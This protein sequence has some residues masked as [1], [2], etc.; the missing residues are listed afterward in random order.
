MENST[1]L[2]THTQTPKN[3]IPGPRGMELYSLG[4]LIKNRPLET[5]RFLHQTWGD[6]VL[7]PWWNRETIFVNNPDAFRYILKTNHTNYTKSYEYK[8]LRPLLGRGLVTSE[9]KEW[10]KNRQIMSQEFHMKRVEKFLPSMEK[11]TEEMLTKWREREDKTFDISEEMMAL[12]FKIAGIAFFG[13]SIEQYTQVAKESLEIEVHRAAQKI[14]SMLPIPDSIPT[15]ANR[16]GQKAISNLEKII[17]TLMGNYRKKAGGEPNILSRLMDYRDENAAGLPPKQ[18][19]DELMTLMLAGHETT[20]NALTWTFYYLAEHPEYQ[21]K[22]FQ[23]IRRLE[24]KENFT[25]EKLENYPML[26][27]CLYE[28]MRLSPPVP[29]VSRSNVE[30][31]V[32]NGYFIPAGSTIVCSIHA[33][34]RDARYW[35]NPSAFKPERFIGREQKADDYTYLPFAKG[36]RACIGERMA[37][38]EAQIILLKII[39]NYR[40]ELV[41]GFRPQPEHSITLRSRNGLKMK[42]HARG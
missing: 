36:P 30:D 22:I 41:E 3:E 14:N 37:M 11:L 17:F 10:R 12:T 1:S 5:F 18:I 16:Q 20:S 26:N 28:S 19:R 2:S 42:M 21:E 13:D 9:G 32:L 23:E 31:D 34:H 27:A 33:I 24:G 6:M 29:G 35:N 39:K 40:F 15:A 4:T 38:L 8:Y 7:A 25:P